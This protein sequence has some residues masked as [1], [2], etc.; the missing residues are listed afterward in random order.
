MRR[1][2]NVLAVFVVAFVVHGCSQRSENTDDIDTPTI[3]VSLLTMQHQ[4]YQDLRAGLE[5]KADELGYEL[6]IAS[7]EFDAARQAD[8][9]DNF[10]VQDV[11]AIV[12]SPCDSRSVGASILAANKMD[13]PVITADIASLAPIGEVMTHVA[14]DNLAGGRLAA[15]LMIKALDGTG[16][17]AILSHPE[18]TSVTDRVKGFRDRIKDEPNIEIVAELSAEGMRDK[19]ARVMED[20]LQAHS[21]LDGVFAINDDSALGALAAIESAGRLEQTAIIGYDGT[22]EARAKIRSGAIYG[23]VIQHPKK[24]G[25]LT[26]DA[27]HKVLKA[28]AVPDVIPVEVGTIT[29]ESL[30]DEHASS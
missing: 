7:A 1:R 8:Q 6:I 17:V 2:L 5:A 25:E 29:A 16:K 4:F 22:P 12:L 9:I 10:I 30:S 3:G 28:T 14:S 15:E 26:I 27:V 23:D 21:D 11:D 19:A 24:I 18:V 13:I 20:L